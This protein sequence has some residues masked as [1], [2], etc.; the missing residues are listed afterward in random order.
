MSSG[1]S[2]YRAPVE[3][4][5]T[6]QSMQQVTIVE[7]ISEGPIVGLVTGDEKSIALNQTPLK[8]SEGAY[9]YQNV[10]WDIRLGAPDQAPFN[11]DGS[12]AEVSVG[13]EVT[14]NF[15]RASGSGS[16]SISRTISNLNCTHVRVTLSVQGL[17][18]QLTDEDRSGDTIG[19]TVDYTVTVKDKNGAVQLTD[20]QARTDKTTSSAQWAKKYALSGTGPW[21][22]TVV[23]NHA[24]NSLSRIK[25]DLY[26]SSYTEI[27]NRKLTYPHTAL[28]MI[29]GNAETFGSSVPSRMYYVKGRIISVPSNYD[30]E[31]RAYTGI[32]DGTFKEAWTDNPAWIL[33]DL[34]NMDRYGLRKRFPETWSKSLFDKWTLYEI[35]K[36][37][38]A[39]VSN[40]YGGT[41]PRFTMGTQI[42]GSG[43]AKEVV[44]TIT[45][46][47]NGM[48]YWGGSQMFASCDYPTDP[49]RSIGQSITNT[50]T[51]SYST[52]SDHEIHSVAMVTWYDQD[53]FGQ[54]TI[55]PVI[56]WDKYQKVGYREVKVTAYGCGSRGQARRRGLWT[57]ATEDEQW[58]QTR[59]M[60]LEGYDLMPGSVVRVADEMI[61]GIKREGR[62]VSFSSNANGNYVTL[63]RDVELE[64]N[65]TYYLHVM[66][67]DGTEEKFT[68]TSRGTG[69]TITISAAPTK[70]YEDRAEWCIVGT[71]VAPRL[72]CVTALKELE[73]GKVQV[74]LRV[75][76][77]NKYAEIEDGLAL[78]TAP[79]RKVKGSIS[80]PVG[81]TVL[82]NTYIE[83][84]TPTQRLT[85]SWGSTGDPDVAEYEPSYCSPSGAWMNFTPQRVFSLD[86]PA[87]MGGDWLF[88]VRSCALDGRL[89][90]WAEKSYTLNAIAALPKAPTNLT[91]TGGIRSITL[92]WEA[93][94]DALVGYYEILMSNT[95]SIDDVTV[96]GKI[97][98]SAFTVMGLGIMETRW[99][100]VRSVSYADNGV[101]SEA[102]GPVSGT[103]KALEMADIPDQSIQPSKFIPALE[104]V[105]AD[106]NKLA[107]A[108]INNAVVTD[109]NRN[110]AAVA[111]QELT[112][113][114]NEGLS[115]EATARTTLA[116]AVNKNTAA[117]QTNAE[118]IA[119]VDGKVEAKYTI[120]V[121]ANGKVAGIVLGTN[122]TTSEFAILAE[123]F[124]VANPVSG[125]EPIQVFSID[126]S[127][128]T[129]KLVMN[130]NLFV[131]AANG[132]G[133]GWIV[134]DM[135]NAAAQ[136]LLGA[137]GAFIGG[138][139]SIFQLGT[140]DS[141]ASIIIDSETGTIK[142]IDP[143]NLT[144][145]DFIK[146]E[147]GSL[148]TY[149]YLLPSAGSTTKSA[150][151][152]RVLRAIETGYASNGATVTLGNRFPTMP[153]IMVS[154]RN[155]VTYIAG[156]SGNQQMNIE[157]ANATYN[158][159]TGIVTFVPVATLTS[160]GS[161]GSFA[162]SSLAGYYQF[163]QIVNLMANNHLMSGTFSISL[164]SATVPAG[165]GTYTVAAEICAM[166]PYLV[167]GKGG[168]PQTGTCYLYLNEDGIDYLMGTTPFI[169]AQYVVTNSEP[170]GYYTQFSITRSNYGTQKTV[171]I[172]AVFYVDGGYARNDITVTNSSIEDYI[173]GWARFVAGS[174]N[175]PGTTLA[176]NGTLNYIA[177]A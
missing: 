129:P 67:N 79:A 55:E 34:V 5:N 115:A 112:T 38:D 165:T 155:I 63:D 139:G 16:G 78:P 136:I 146:I 160:T 19:Q 1:S 172:K 130:G 18:E 77:E 154:P 61:M 20:H 51:L 120:V 128:D 166:L 81:L 150:Y 109:N 53:N 65:E 122:G 159:Q 162:P 171:F 177:I 103:T 167:D 149:K 45:S 124:Y 151:A 49:V 97:Y 113:H 110:T 94:N 89:S 141:G 140:T 119:T 173:R 100:W 85:F 95:E 24:D 163:E 41:E 43:E 148:A 46:V 111:T 84:G 86:V 117:V 25:N 98:G 106:V 153:N 74:S 36:I 164:A 158:S 14:H 108:G 104:R 142:V 138:E 87:A 134:G 13:L 27:I 4:P 80:S 33:Y 168:Y 23:K 28:M 47:F 22:V 3:A 170:G 133:G 62:M 91:A 54:A 40:G 68:I 137:G 8:T 126:S 101:M 26:W 174:Y 42:T 73:K 35:A 52:G 10:G 90:D 75:V 152:M 157:A 131:N 107:N 56:D 114:V 76:N 72:F 88:R 50:G 121:D 44:Q 102:V 48:S 132:A 135:I 125:G 39:T 175:Y 99:F 147:S 37:C 66:S 127:G 30:P 6:L 69:A 176:A 32:W 60:G 9:T 161:S 118:A 92:N 70:I 82:A 17:Y 123:H 143:T 144:T 169:T 12:E 156:A 15:P 11:V 83:N 29:R 59:E 71:D 58:Q 116:V 57:L 105:I 21:T 64:N 7:A 2:S 93:A 96:A 145:G 31:T